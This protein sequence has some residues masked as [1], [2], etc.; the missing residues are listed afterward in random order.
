MAEKEA[1]SIEPTIDETPAEQA[2]PETK[3]K[4]KPKYSPPPTGASKKGTY[5]LPS[6]NTVTN[7]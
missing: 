6:G 4:G 2:K 7:A 1:K 3:G 5:K